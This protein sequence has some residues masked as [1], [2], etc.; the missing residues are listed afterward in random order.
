VNGFC[1]HSN[2]YVELNNGILFEPNTVLSMPDRRGLIQPTAGNSIGVQDAL[3]DGVYQM[4]LVSMLPDI[5]AGLIDLDPKWLP[6]YITSSTVKTVPRTAGPS[7]FDA[8][9]VHV[10]TCTGGQKIN[11]SA[12][13]LFQDMI[14]VTNCEIHFASDAQLI[15]AVIATTHTGANSI[16]SAAK[17]TIGRDDGCAAD[18]GSQILSLGSIDFSAGLELFGGQIVATDD[19]SFAANATG[20]EGASIVAG[21]VVS[22]TSNM[23]MGFCGGG[24][25][26]NF[27]AVYFRL[28][29]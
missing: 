6:D 18:G 17:M 21:G 27:S 12:N 16:N 5:I 1:V 29:I 11:F 4:R 28:A 15:N 26:R 13:M 10:I 2:E 22:G 19:I 14:L 8:G 9:T 23:T 20:V 24:M 25:E 3:R 7:D